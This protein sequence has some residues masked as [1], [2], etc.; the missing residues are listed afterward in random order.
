MNGFRF[1][2]FWGL[3]ATVEGPD[4]LL[5]LIFEDTARELTTAAEEEGEEELI[6]LIDKTFDD[7]LLNF[8][9]D[10]F[11]IVAPTDVVG[12]TDFEESS[13]FSSLLLPYNKEPPIAFRFLIIGSSS[14]FLFWPKKNTFR[15]ILYF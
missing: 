1:G 14:V 4:L 11:D 10:F 2:P 13:E 7:T 5:R 15:Y 9:F 12:P 3:L 6:L 8:E